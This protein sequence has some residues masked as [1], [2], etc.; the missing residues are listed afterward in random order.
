M[1]SLLLVFVIW[2]WFFIKTK[3]IP[4]HVISFFKEP[5]NRLNR[6]EGRIGVRPRR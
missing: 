1:L 5:D 4:W 6:T 2:S 3:T